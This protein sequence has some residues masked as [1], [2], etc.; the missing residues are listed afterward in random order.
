MDDWAMD[1]PVQAQYE[2]YPYPARDPADEAKRLIVASPSHIDEIDH[3]VCA[4]RRDFTRP[5][6]VLFAGG[7]TGDGLMMLAQQLAD[8][9]GPAEITYL[10]VSAASAKIAAERAK[11]RGLDSIRFVQGSLLDVADLA[12]GPYD[13]IDC[14]GVLHHLPEPAAGLAALAGVLAPDGG[15]GVMLYGTLG[16]IGVY[17]MQDALQLLVADEPAEARIG[18][19]RKLVDGLP[20]TNWFRRNPFVADHREGGDAGLFDLLLHSRDRAYRVPEVLALAEGAGLAVTDFIEPLLYEPA[21]YLTDAALRKRAEALPEAERWTL[22]ELL[23]GNFK[24]H[25]CYMVPQARRATARARLADDQALDAVVPV[26]REIDPESF[27]KRHKPGGSLDIE[28]NRL[29]LS[30][31]LPRLGPVMVARIDNK[32]TLAEL[33]AVLRDEIDSRLEE[34][35]FRS[36]FAALYRVLNGLNRLYL[37]FV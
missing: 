37:R 21:T 15:M 16:R 29:R 30:F 6:K 5:F 25:V 20:A 23:A 17:H 4:G 22:A 13:Y 32:R 14:C 1:D 26:L 3:F 2:A 31:P 12:P 24:V 28:T 9:G 8:R 33:Y 10:D 27:A 35:A 36:Q 19:A 34:P 11:V 18:L 7:G